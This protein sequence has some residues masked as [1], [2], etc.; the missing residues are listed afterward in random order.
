MKCWLWQHLRTLVSMPQPDDADLLH[1][2]DDLHVVQHMHTQKQ[3]MHCH[4]L[5]HLDLFEEVGDVLVVKRQAATQQRIQDDTAAPHVHLWARI[6]L[7]RDDLQHRIVSQTAEYCI[8]N[9]LHGRLTLFMIIPRLYHHTL[10]AMSV[11]LICTGIP[12]SCSWPQS[13]KPLLHLGRSIVGR[14]AAGFQEVA[15]THHVAE[16]KVCNLHVAVCVQQQ[17]LRLQVS[18]HDLQLSAHTSHAL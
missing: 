11:T 15:V 18:V 5:T 4:A 10:P 17:V 13:R 1:Y 9:L 16:P 8:T 2:P 3:E 6:Q 14:P 12:L 7:A